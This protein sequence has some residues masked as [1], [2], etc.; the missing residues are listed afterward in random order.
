MV[1]QTMNNDNEAALQWLDDAH[2]FARRE[3]QWKLVG[4]LEVVR[5]EIVFEIGIQSFGETCTW[6]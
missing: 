2:R 3:D 6:G 5:A 4:L 1:D